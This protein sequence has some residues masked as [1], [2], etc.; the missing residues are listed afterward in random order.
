MDPYTARSPRSRRDRISV[1]AA[2]ALGAGLLLG[3]GGWALIANGDECARDE[4]SLVVKADPAIAP[5]AS[6]LAARE[7]SG[8]CAAVKVTAEASA[9]TAAAISAGRNVPDVWIPDSELWLDLARGGPSGRTVLGRSASVA[10]SPLLIAY[11]PDEGAPPD[12]TWAGL[13]AAQPDGTGDD[14]PE[15]GNDLVVRVPDPARTAAGMASLL[16]LQDAIGPGQGFTSLKRFA[17]TL[18]TIETLDPGEDPRAAL[19]EPAEGSSAQVAVVSEQQ[20]TRWP[21]GRPGTVYPASG[22]PALD[23]PFTVTT[24]DLAKQH[25]ADDLLRRFQSPSGV[26]ELNRRGLRGGGGAKAAAGGALSTPLP[27]ILPLASPGAASRIQQTWRS[28]KQEINVLALVDP[29]GPAGTAMTGAAWRDAIGPGGNR[30]DAMLVSLNRGLNLV[31]DD[32]EFGL[33]TTSGAARRSYRPVVGIGELGGRT[34]TATTHR[35][36]LE[37]RLNAIR[38]R[39]GRDGAIYESVVAAYREMKRRYDADQINVVLVLTA[40]GAD[41][42][43]SAQ[44]GKALERLRREVDPARPI[45]FVVV[46]F[47]SGLDPGLKQLTGAVQGQSFQ[48][49]NPEGI[50]ELFRNSDLM[51]VCSPPQC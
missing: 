50:E 41:G 1:A 32:S 30:L 34:R 35:L 45:V 43:P 3:G 8:R 24:A 19:S 48:I 51:R 16:A 44:F 7:G 37:Q 40:M 21:A 33:W 27:R 2:V 5:A 25:R 13:L 31:G 46:G 6:A 14:P 23:F 47:G 15:A 17:A 10:V 22:T 9:D 36:V 26:A 38:P 28:F 39:R 11:P 18:R 49:R 4:A 20:A 12:R 42:H 29:S